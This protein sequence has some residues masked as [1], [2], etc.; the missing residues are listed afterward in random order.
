[1]AELRRHPVSG[2][3]V[4]ICPE[5]GLAG[6]AEDSNGCVFCP[7]SEALT[8]REVY[9]IPG[10]GGYYGPNWQVRVVAESPPL[11]HVEGEFAKKA[12]G[13]CDCMEAIG[14]HEIL[15]DSPIHGQDLEGLDQYQ[16]ISILD[17]LR[18]RAA[19]LGGD[20][21]LRQVMVFKVR[22]AGSKQH[23]RWHIVSTPFVP[24]VIKEELN[25]SAKYYAYKERCVFCDYIR[26]ERKLDS[27]VICEEPGAVAL[28]PYA[29]RFPYE[30]AT[31]LILR[32]PPGRT[33]PG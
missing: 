32:T 19:D 31:R 6:G 5:K 10:S 8:G 9:R 28:S 24:G 25:G 27:R 20:E 18:S 17:V 23:P 21:R 7:G 15:L 14:A 22:V 29:A 1:M 26:Q 16:I 4:V 2:E 12:A 13:L 33:S 30:A 11:F 3:W